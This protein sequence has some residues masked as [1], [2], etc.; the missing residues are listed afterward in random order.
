MILAGECGAFS[1]KLLGC[2]K[3]V[4]GEFEALAQQNSQGGAAY[5]L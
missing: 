1:P 5:H 4:R 3:K 2:F